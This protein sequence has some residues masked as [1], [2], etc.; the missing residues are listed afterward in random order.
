VLDEKSEAAALRG[1]TPR[2]SCTYPHQFIRQWGQLW[3]GYSVFSRLFMLTT[4]R[5]L[6]TYARSLEP[7]VEQKVDCQRFVPP[8]FGR[9]EDD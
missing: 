1:G 4:D 7:A 6:F 3:L 2:S 8:R 9:L 5:Q